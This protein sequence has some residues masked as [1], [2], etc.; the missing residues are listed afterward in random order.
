MHN[1][2]A[3]FWVHKMMKLFV[4][5]ILTILIVIPNGLAN[6]V[7]DNNHRSD[8][9]TITKIVNDFFDWYVTSVKER[10]YVEFR[11]VFAERADGMTTLD[12]SAYIKNL[13]EHSFSYEL[14][15]QEKQ[16]YSEC[17][18]KLGEIKYNKFK[19][20]YIDLD[21]FENILCDFTNYYRW[22]GGMEPIEHFRIKN[23]KIEKHRTAIVLVEFSYFNPDNRDEL[24]FEGR[25]V[26]LKSEENNWKIRKI[27]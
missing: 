10:K 15:E 5:C 9:T 14:I 23:V 11:P 1:R 4:S 17:I 7:I 25:S 22:T 16:Y 26:T 13:K 19:S 24:F 8:S 20:E 12:F 27:E 2:C 6:C 3:A 18:K 21:Q